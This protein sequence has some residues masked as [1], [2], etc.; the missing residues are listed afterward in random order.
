MKLYYAQNSRAVRVAWLLEELGLDYETIKFTLGEPAMRE[1]GYLKLHPAGRVPTL[2]DGAVTIFESGAIVQ[3]LL[4][5]HGNGRLAPP[6]DAPEFP[7]YLQWFHYCEGM[8]M[9][10]VNT[11][12]VE[13]ILLPPERR[14]ELN[15]KRAAKLLNQMLTP[16]AAHI[17]GRD[18]LAGDFS[19]ADIM[20]G[21]AV[22]VS[23]DLLKADFS[24]KP[25]LSAYADRLLERPALQ[26]AMNL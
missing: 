16:L 21:H 24:D 5:R 12:V 17:Q 10:P 22:I 6:V 14:T 4:A 7:A 2:E 25:A 26:R 13:T 18:Y 11:L 1:P 8:I 15:V 9:V 23:R 20:T 19:A 3:Y